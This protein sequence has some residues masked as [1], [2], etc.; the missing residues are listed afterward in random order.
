M[1]KALRTLEACCTPF[2]PDLS[3]ARQFVLGGEVATVTS[4]PVSASYVGPDRYHESWVSYED[5][6]LLGRFKG[7]VVD[8]DTVPERADGVHVLYDTTLVLP[9]VPVLP[10]IV[11]LA[12]WQLESERRGEF[13]VVVMVCTEGDY[14]SIDLTSSTKRGNDY[15][16]HS[17]ST[18]VRALAFA[19]ATGAL[20]ALED[21]EGACYELSE[22]YTGAGGREPD[23]SWR[24]TTALSAFGAL[25]GAG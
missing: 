21:C 5:D 23:A 14:G 9:E 10:S 24:L 25:P 3:T 22:E 18:R 12:D 16:L 19:R 7:T 11:T 6:P 8:F 2:A 17:R 4:Q 13:S 20:L 15:I 1:A